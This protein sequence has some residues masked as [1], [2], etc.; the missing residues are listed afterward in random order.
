MKLDAYCHFFHGVPFADLPSLYRMATVFAYPSRIEG[1]GIPLL[2]AITSGVPAIGCTGSCLEE[3]GGKD[4]IYVGPDDA[5]R[6]GESIA[7]LLADNS[8]RQSMR[9]KGRDYALKNFSDS[10]L[11]RDLM[12]VYA[13]AMEK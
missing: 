7:R 8:M 4:S 3:A 2:E 9:E 1:F 6:L 10:K 12:D 11:S 13:K 5:N